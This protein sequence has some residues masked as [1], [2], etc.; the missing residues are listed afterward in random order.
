MNALDQ[1]GGMTFTDGNLTTASTSASW[2]STRGTFGVTQGKWYW[3]VKVVNTGGSL[4]DMMVGVSDI[5][6]AIPAEFSS[7]NPAL[8]YTAGSGNKQLNGSNTSYG[9]TYNVGD[10]IGVAFD[11]DALTVIF[12]KNGTSQGT[13]TTGWSSGLTWS[14]AISLY[15][16]YSN[17]QA[18]WNFGNPPYSANSYTDGAGYGN[19]SYSVPSGY[20]SLNTKNLANFGF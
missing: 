9:A 11:A 2:R 1:N 10:I 3:E 12:Y 18:S 19:F 14:P 7:S 8:T 20:Y 15:G 16:R 17:T 13:I 6:I 4:L 5:S